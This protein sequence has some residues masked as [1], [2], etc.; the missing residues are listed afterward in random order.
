[1]KKY[2]SPKGTIS[3]WSY[4]IRTFLQTFLVVFIVGLYLVAVTSYKRASAG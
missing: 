3:G 4:F 1:M 2:F